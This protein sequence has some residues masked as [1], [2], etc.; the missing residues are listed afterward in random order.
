M[1]K[2]NPFKS[3]TF[4]FALVAIALI[5]FS[6]YLDNKFKMELLNIAITSNKPF[7]DFLPFIVNIPIAQVITFSTV[8]T[9]GYVGKRL[10]DNATKNIQLPTGQ[11]NQSQE[12]EEDNR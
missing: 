10:T 1:G 12:I 3:T 4:W 11:N 7:V 8:V 9:G 5:P 6:F 2:R